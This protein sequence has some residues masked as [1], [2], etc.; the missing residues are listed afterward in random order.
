MFVY[1]TR[2]R[3]WA[4]RENLSILLLR[5]VASPQIC[6][7]PRNSPKIRTYSTSRSSK[8]ISLVANRKPIYNFLLVINSNYGRISY[9]FRGIDA[10]SSKIA[11][12]PPLPC[13]TPP[14]GG[15]PCHMNVIYTPHRHH[16]FMM[17]MIHRCKAHSMGYNSVADTTGLSWFVSRCCFPKSPDHAKLRQNLTLQ[18]FKVIQGHRSWCQWKAHIRLVINSYFG[19]NCYRLRYWCSKLDKKAML[20]QGNR[21]MPL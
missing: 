1:V 16:E 8:V 20:S 17:S 6:E 2:P 13:L 21:A 14:S 15:T 7:I 9:R 12:F 11:C 10:F 5:V 18:Q 4:L 3:R 19:R